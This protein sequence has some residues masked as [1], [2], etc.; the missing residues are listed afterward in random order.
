MRDDFYDAAPSHDGP[1]NDKGTYM[2][3]KHLLLAGA[4]AMALGACGGEDG[5]AE[6]GAASNT[7]T[8]SV[9]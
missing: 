2:T 8:K 9:V 3:M 6:G 7:S 4:A 1:A 5:G